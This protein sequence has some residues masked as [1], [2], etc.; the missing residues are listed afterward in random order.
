[1]GHTPLHHATVIADGVAHQAHLMH[2]PESFLGCEWRGR[3]QWHS[4]TGLG[5]VSNLP[6]DS[7]Y[8]K[9]VYEI[10]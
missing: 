4:E 6:W 8:D 3:E 10:A 7:F 1:M 9:D 2:K 5:N